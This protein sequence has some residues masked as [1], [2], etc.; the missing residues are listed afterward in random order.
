MCVHIMMM[1]TM[2]SYQG[3]NGTRFFLEEESSQVEDYE[4]DVVIKKGGVHL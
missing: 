2:E 3:T 4:H 1:M